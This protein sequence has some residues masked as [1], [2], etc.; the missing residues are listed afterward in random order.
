M[1]GTDGRDGIGGRKGETTK[2]TK[3]T[4]RRKQEQPQMKHRW[5][6][7]WPRIYAE[8]VERERGS[9]NCRKGQR[10]WPARFSLPTLLIL[11]AVVPARNFAGLFRKS[12]TAGM[13]IAMN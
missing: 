1:G 13:Q 4:K 5:E 2:D 9:T 11:T 7:I 10:V 6:A 3:Y 8:Y 12:T